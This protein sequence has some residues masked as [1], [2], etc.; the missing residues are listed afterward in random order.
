MLLE[1]SVYPKFTLRVQV[2][3]SHRRT[4][5]YPNPVIHVLL[6]KSQVPKYWVL[7][8][9]GLHYVR[10]V[11]HQIPFLQGFIDLLLLHYRVGSKMLLK[12]YD[13]E[14]LPIVGGP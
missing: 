7:G 2:L 4:M 1:S 8:L 13:L 5:M 10:D 12:I 9:L 14:N 11:L 3:N 6:P